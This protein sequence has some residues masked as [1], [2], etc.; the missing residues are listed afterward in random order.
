MSQTPYK[1][2]LPC[3]K[4]I[5]MRSW[6]DRD[7]NLEI[8]KG[9]ESFRKFSEQ[10]LRKAFCHK[11]GI[12]AF[13]NVSHTPILRTRTMAGGG[14]QALENHTKFENI[15]TGTPAGH[16]GLSAYR[17]ASLT[18]DHQ[19][20]VSSN[21]DTIL[22]NG[23]NGFSLTDSSSSQAASS[24]GSNWLKMYHSDPSKE[25]PISEMPNPLGGPLTPYNQPG[26]HG[27]L[28]GPLRPTETGFPPLSGPELPST[29]PSDHPYDPTT[30]LDGPRNFG[31]KPVAPTEIPT[32][33]GTLQMNGDGSTVL[34]KNDGST[35]HADK[36]H[37]VTEVD[38]ADGSKSEIG[39]DEKGNVASIKS[40]SSIGQETDLGPVAPGEVTV[41]ADG[42]IQ[43]KNGKGGF[44]T[45]T[46]G[47]EVMADKDGKVLNIIHDGN[48]LYSAFDHQKRDHDTTTTFD[49][50]T[51]KS[52]TK[53]TDGSTT[54]TEQN[55][56]I[57][58]ISKGGQISFRDASGNPNPGT[59][60][61]PNGDPEVAPLVGNVPV[62]AGLE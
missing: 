25:A 3:E 51:G 33:D 17:G 34:T 52:E 21:L 60:L 36:D 38:R 12:N 23:S 24:T 30:P 59:K 1:C 13:H 14:Q 61:D 37:R 6:S 11:V 43:A 20:P 10:S 47:T 41:S 54:F 57:I 42:T 16:D 22:G 53:R 9:G 31:D 35:V 48:L 2:G 19:A 29:Q 8:E 56:T 4:S 15:T 7:L 44:T 58:D 49:D 50:G 62:P 27:A 18:S 28:G 40:T 46:D 32:P 55:G 5:L 39:Y 45:Y 26:D